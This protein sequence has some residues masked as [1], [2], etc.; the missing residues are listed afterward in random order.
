MSVDSDKIIVDL[1]IGKYTD[2]YQKY[3]SVL[4]EFTLINR[5]TTM[6]KNLSPY[7]F[8][9]IHKHVEPKIL[10]GD[11]GALKDLNYLNRRRLMTIGAA[12]SENLFLHL[13][14]IYTLARF[15]ITKFS[16]LSNEDTVLATNIMAEFKPSEPQGGQ[17]G[18]MKDIVSEVKS[19]ITPEI[20]Q[21]FMNRVNTENGPEGL[22]QSVMG[23]VK[24]DG[25]LD[26]DQFGDEFSDLVTSISEKMQVKIDQGVSVDSLMSETMKMLATTRDI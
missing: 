20:I 3:I 15:A 23:M 5:N 16:N 4:E 24:Q 21:V 14:T 2:A 10:A 22:M 9:D 26:R 7:T 17:E 12:S 18:S 8:V 1:F 6:S 11:K 19:A 13:A 25:T